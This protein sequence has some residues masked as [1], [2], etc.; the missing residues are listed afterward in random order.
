MRC[1]GRWRSWAPRCACPLDRPSIGRV[2]AAHLSGLHIRSCAVVVHRMERPPTS[3]DEA[4]LIIG[5]DQ[6]RG[7]S[8]VRRRRQFP[9]TRAGARRLQTAPP[10]H[11]DGAAAL[12]PDGSVGLVPAGD[13]SA[14]RRRMRVDPDA[15]QRVAEGHGA[16][17]AP[18]ARRFARHGAAERRRCRRQRLLARDDDDRRGEDADFAEGLD[19][20]HPE[21]RAGD[22]RRIGHAGPGENEPDIV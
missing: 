22:V 19:Q 15:D 4:R 2:L 21:R 10:P 8:H 12:L 16:A 9:R 6:E 11:G 17:A 5:W 7:L 13:G 1:G 18:G 14:A 3:N 20:R